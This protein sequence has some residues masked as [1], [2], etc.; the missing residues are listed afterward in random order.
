M[1]S[2]KKEVTDLLSVGSGIEFALELVNATRASVIFAPVLL[3]E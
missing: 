2:N 3:N 1:L